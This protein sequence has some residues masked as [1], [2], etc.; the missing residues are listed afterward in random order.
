M[1]AFPVRDGTIELPLAPGV[2]L[3]TD[4]RERYEV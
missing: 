4:I 3:A 1:R 2:L